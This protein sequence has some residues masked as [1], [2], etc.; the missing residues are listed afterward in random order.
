MNVVDEVKSRVKLES[1]TWVQF[2]DAIVRVADSVNLPTEEQ[3]F[4]SPNR[5]NVLAYKIAEETLDEAHKPPVRPS[6]LTIQA[7]KTRP[8][9][10]K[11]AMLLD[12]M[13]RWLDHDVSH[14]RDF[15][16]ARLLKDIKKKDHDMGS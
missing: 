6:H 15:N 16:K 8:L 5:G 9:H 7:P 11:I 3:L 2:L 14:P 13:F 1:M 12:Y 10:E 4:N